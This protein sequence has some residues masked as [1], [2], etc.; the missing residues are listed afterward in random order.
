MIQKFFN[1]VCDF[2]ILARKR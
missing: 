1:L 2:V